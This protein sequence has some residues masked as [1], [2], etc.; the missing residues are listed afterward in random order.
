MQ[1]CDVMADVMAAQRGRRG[2]SG[3]CEQRL[4]VAPVVFCGMRR[5]P[6]L[7]R[8]MLEISLQ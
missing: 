4:D 2:A 6:A 1:S 5:E 7:M 3:H 8:Q